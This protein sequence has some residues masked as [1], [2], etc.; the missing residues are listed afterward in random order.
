VLGNHPIEGRGLFDDMLRVHREQAG[1]GYPVGRGIV[2]I[3]LLEQADKER[4]FLDR[5]SLNV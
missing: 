3:V 4:C 1:K 2:S 5:P